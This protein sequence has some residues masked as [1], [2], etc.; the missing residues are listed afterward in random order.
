VLWLWLRRP[1][2]PQTPWSRAMMKL[3]RGLEAAGLP[4]PT[5]C[6]APAPAL[7]WLNSLRSTTPPEG[8]ANDAALALAQ[9]LQALD[10]LRYARPDAQGRHTAHQRQLIQAA[11]EQARRMGLGS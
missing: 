9:S 1:R 5:G 3:H 7:A 6:P 2:R 4:E 8:D 11:L 10:A